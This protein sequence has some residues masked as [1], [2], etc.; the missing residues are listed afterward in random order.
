MK[1][2]TAVVN[3]GIDVSQELWIRIQEAHKDDAEHLRNFN[4][5]TFFPF[6]SHAV[7][8]YVGH[9]RFIMPRLSNNNSGISDALTIP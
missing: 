9:L 5:P 1:N 6:H 2:L 3:S 8:V 4:V 7:L